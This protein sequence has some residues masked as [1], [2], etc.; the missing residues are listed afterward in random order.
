VEVFWAWKKLPSYWEKHSI[1]D[2]ELQTVVRHLAIIKKEFVIKYYFAEAVE[3]F[4]KWRGIDQ[5][6]HF[7]I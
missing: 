5:K 3:A 6:G 7:C 4:R 1:P 2:E